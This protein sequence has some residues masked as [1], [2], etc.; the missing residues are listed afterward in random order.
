MEPA[1]QAEWMG[2]ILQISGELTTTPSLTLLLRRIVEAAAELTDSESAGIL[3]QNGAVGELRF[4]AATSFADQLFDIPVPIEASIAGAAFRDG[5]P[6][7]VQE[8][9]RD[10]RYFDVIEQQTGFAARSLLAVPLQFKKR[11]IGVLEV[12]NKRKGD[13]DDTDVQKLT[14][15]GAQA[16][17]AITNARIVSELQQTRQMLERRVAE[18]VAELSAANNALHE[19]IAEREHAE[20]LLRER[21]AQ[22]ETRN[23][24]L[25]AFAH[26]VAHDLRGPLTALIGLVE[27]MGDHL[28]DFA[29]AQ[30]HNYLGLAVQVGRKMNNIIDE[31]LCLASVRDEEIESSPLD[32][33]QIVA[34]AW[35]RLKPLVT[36]QQAEIVLPDEWPVARGHAPWIEE[37]WVN[38]LSN[39][40]K[41]GGHPPHIELGATVQPNGEVRFW[42]A[43]NGPGL[44]PK[45]QARLFVPFTRLEQA[46][47]EGYGLGLSIVHR[48]MERLGGQVGVESVPGRGSVFFFTL[49]AGQPVR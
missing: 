28:P 5:R 37:V 8:A 18:R 20:Q 10:P 40:L 23:E 31:L 6:I 24:E 22:L 1:V 2:Q 29:I 38:Y 27:M 13:F 34:S 32:M 11:R 14:A 9:S 16:T 47:A 4:V 35:T 12:Q 19:Q 36:E 48:I 7:L 49:P 25:D 41:Y 21:T 44:A 46:R 17:V 3:L 43:D 42:V 39:A 33:A 45:D 15:L 26:T 30:Q